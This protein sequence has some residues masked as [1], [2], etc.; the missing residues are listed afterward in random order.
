MDKKFLNALR[1]VINANQRNSLFE[2]M[3]TELPINNN[4][5]L[6]LGDYMFYWYKTF[7]K[8]GKK[9]SVSPTKSIFYGDKNN[10]EE[11][12]K[13]YA[14][15]KADIIS[16]ESFVF[17]EIPRD[18]YDYFK[19]EFLDIMYY[20]KHSE[21]TGKYTKK[22]DL[23]TSF[24]SEVLNISNQISELQYKLE[25][26]LS[27][28]EEDQ[29]YTITETS[30]YKAAP[31]GTWRSDKYHFKVYQGG[32][33]TVLS[34]PKVG[35]TQLV[36]DL[37]VQLE[38]AGFH[39]ILFDLENGVK[40]YNARRIQSLL[41]VDQY[42]LLSNKCVIDTHNVPYYNPLSN[43]LTNDLVGVY[44]HRLE[45]DKNTPTK[46]FKTNN[47]KYHSTYHILRA[48]TNITRDDDFAKILKWDGSI[49]ESCINY[50]EFISGDYDIQYTSIDE[51]LSFMN[52]ELFIPIGGQ[53]LIKFVQAGTPKDIR[54]VID[55]VI[56]KD[57]DKPEGFFESPDNRVMMI[58]WAGIIQGTSQKQQIWEKTHQIY[59]EL[60]R[61]RVEVPGLSQ[62][63][64]EGTTTADVLVDDAV[65]IHD[66]KSSGSNRTTFDVVNRYHLVCG[67]KHRQRGLRLMIAAYDRYGG[68]LYDY[69][70]YNHTIQKVTPITKEEYNF[71]MDD[72][73]TTSKQNKVTNNDLD[74]II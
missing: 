13:V 65:A 66:V 42:C 36:I 33:T 45:Y 62:L 21:L 61:L 57:K 19:K 32:L 40:Q 48:K 46:G 34:G 31:I 11:Y 14:S 12:L 7:V 73:S 50:W 60:Q 53:S 47:I 43:Y 72:D 35:K 64:V 17:S 41:S 27:L 9:Y 37:L 51:M 55:N 1:F 39:V 68:I 74:I 30:E 54:R 23:N 16:L 4:L 25:S 49:N 15:K 52:K 3:S 38:Q 58:D 69:L 26:I 29:V 5:L 2:I 10:Y 20:F 18:D 24:Q 67:E 70:L 6:V 71:I 8:I 59:T 44:I 63:M 56:F 28:K 22:F